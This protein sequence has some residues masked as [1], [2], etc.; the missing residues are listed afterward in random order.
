MPTDF[1][2][3]P[4]TGDILI[5]KNNLVVGDAT[6]QRQYDLC[7]ADKGHYK[8]QPSRGVGLRNYLNDEGSMPGLTASIRVELINDNQTVESVTI[9]QGGMVAI[10]ASVN[11]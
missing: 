2:F 9:Q 4:V 7:L 5:D 6:K 1:L 10:V 11:Q 3:D 8:H